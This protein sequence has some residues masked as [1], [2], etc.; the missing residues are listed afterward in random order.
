MRAISPS[1]LVLTVLVPVVIGIFLALPSGGG[2]TPGGNSPAEDGGVSSPF[3]TASNS[4]AGPPR[5]EENRGCSGT[6]VAKL[7]TAPFPYHG[8]YEDTNVKFFDYVDPRTAV[9][10]HTNRDGARFP[11]KDHYSDGSVLFHIPPTFRPKEPF[12]FVV[13]FH[14]INTNIHQSN[15][16]YDLEGQI[17]ASG[18]NV[19]LVMPQMAKD[20]ADSSPGKFFRKGA[21]KAFMDEAAG[22]LT[23]RLGKKYRDRLRQAPIILVG[24][25][26]GYKA[27]AYTLDRGGAT[28]RIEG[29]ILLDAFY[30][31]V[32]KFEKWI[33]E[34]IRK[35]FL[36]DIY[37]SGSCERN[38]MEL[39]ARL[40][41]KG[42]RPNWDWPPHAVS[43]GNLYFVMSHGNHMDIPLSGPPREPLANVL[44]LSN[45]G[46][47]K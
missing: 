31:E 19:I 12:A 11:E 27:V 44:R 37:T 33:Y 16:D 2:A 14:A 23:D 29:V 39:A 1:L 5:S 17:D 32:D 35:S 34:N 25:S 42:L 13:F 45:V 21:F 6:F 15:S 28:R 47:G 10:Y 4:K 18:G 20:A 30:G 41:R 3:Q 36:V 24:F 26:G 43:K 7:K 38:S 8:K 22:E 9:R 40:D 46:K